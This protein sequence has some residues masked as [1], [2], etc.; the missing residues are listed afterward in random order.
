[1]R[2]ALPLLRRAGRVAVVTVTE[3]SAAVAVDEVARHLAWHEVKASGTVAPQN[4]TVMDTLW[5]CAR[6]SHAT[7]VVMGA[8]SRSPLRELAFGGCTQSV[9]SR[10]DLPVL[11]VP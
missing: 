3:H 8:F 4:R 7:L 11:L 6:D 1:M 5:A 9:L 2:A 10:G